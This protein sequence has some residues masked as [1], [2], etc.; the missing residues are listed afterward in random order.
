M[1][2]RK[3]RAKV[4]AKVEGIVKRFHLK[5]VFFEYLPSSPA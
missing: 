3:G 2:K 4:K 1:K 5:T